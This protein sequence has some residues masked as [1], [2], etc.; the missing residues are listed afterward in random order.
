MK[1]VCR[2]DICPAVWFPTI[3]AGSGV[4][5]FTERLCAG[6][7]ARG[8]RAE[9]TWLPLRAEYAPWSLPA[10][11]PPPWANIAHANTWLPSRF[12]P[13][14]I[15]LVATMHHCVHGPDLTRYKTF[16]QALYH[17]FWIFP[18]ERKVIKRAARI[19]AVSHYTAERTRHFFQNA[20]ITVI[21][22]A[23]S[24]DGL[25]RYTERVSPHKPFRLLF[26]GKQS[27]RKGSDLLAPI[28]RSLGPE[29]ELMHT[30]PSIPGAPT[31]MRSIGKDLT[32]TELA[33]QYQTSDALLFP[34]RLEGFGLVALEA[35]ACGLPVIATRGSS[36]PEVI[37]DGVTGLLCPQDDVR[38]FA[39]AARW[40]AAHPEQWQAMRRAARKRAETCFDFETMIDRYLA[41][42]RCVLA[43]RPL[44]RQSFRPDRA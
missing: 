27:T 35:Q 30:G 41:L 4:D 6:L 14:S 15:P 33:C 13:S 17:R 11:K 44:A 18:I 38:A 39:E 22:N 29:F 42:Y 5:V 10:P 19:S 43:A 20:D 7:R 12:L 24:L 2:T 34:S 25:F 36:L 23:V 3:R 8:V 28:M 40:L 37:E 1:M 16:F 26:V 9:I 21:Y 32:P 31:N